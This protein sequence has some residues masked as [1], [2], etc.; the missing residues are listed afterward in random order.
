MRLRASTVVR[1]FAT[2]L[3]FLR[4]ENLFRLMGVI[5]VLILAGAVGLTWFEENRS[6]PDAIWWAIVTLTTVGFGDIAPVSLGG[7]LIGVV[8]MFFGIGVLGMFTATIAGVFVEQRMRKERG[9]ELVLVSKEHIILCGWNDRTKEILK[10][11]CGPIARAAEAPTSCWWP[12]STRSR[13][14]TSKLHFVR[15]DVTEENLKTGRH[16]EAR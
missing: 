2:L 13:S 6:F 12:T 1:P 14:W 16:R 11:I 4:R 3:V 15:G 10:P 5:V 8:L 7:R 9:M